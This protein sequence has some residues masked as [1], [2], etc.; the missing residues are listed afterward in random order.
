[1]NRARRVCCRALACMWLA[2]GAAAC[3]PAPTNAPASANVP[4]LYTPGSALGVPVPAP[5]PDAGG[6]GTVMERGPAT[7]GCKG[8]FGAP[9]TAGS[10]TV[11]FSTVEVGGAWHPANVG[12]V[13]IEWIDPTDPTNFKKERFVRTVAKWAAE[14]IES[15]ETWTTRICANKEEMDAVSK[16]TFPDHSQMHMGEWDTKDINGQVVPDGDY[17]LY[18]EVTEFEEQGPISSF[19]FTK[20]PT[21]LMLPPQ[22]GSNVKGLTL[23]Y[24][25]TPPP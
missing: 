18:V 1:M 13:W 12:A 17:K 20:G 9:G 10:L 7:D 25:P 22:D 23:T 8:M 14:R 2:F 3:T 21:A 5:L 19:K 16:A 15:L 24:T 11:T 4:S 6:F